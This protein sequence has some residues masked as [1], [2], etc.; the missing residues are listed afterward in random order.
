MLI[1]SVPR[2]NAGRWRKNGSPL[3]AGLCVLRGRGPCGGGRRWRC[4]GLRR[5]RP[6]A[7]SLV[8]SGSH[9]FAKTASVADHAGTA[10]KPTRAPPAPGPSPTRRRSKSEAPPTAC[11]RSTAPQNEEVGLLVPPG[12]SAKSPG[13]LPPTPDVDPDALQ[14]RDHH[15]ASRPAHRPPCVSPPSC[16]YR[17]HLVLPVHPHPMRVERRGNFALRGNQGSAL[18]FTRPGAVRRRSE[19]AARWAPAVAPGAHGFAE[20]ASYAFRN[21]ASCS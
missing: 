9:A 11:F 19:I 5:G 15:H 18:C 13:S 10:A 20:T 3:R 12:E 17:A 16:K 4:G 21:A 14:L 1:Q 2:R 7:Q 6:G 8:G